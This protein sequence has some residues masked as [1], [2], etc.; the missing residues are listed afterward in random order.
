MLAPPALTVRPLP[1]A[2][3]A[4]STPRSVARVPSWV[5]STADAV[6]VVA[7]DIT[8]RKQA[9]AALL[10]DNDTW[11]ATSRFRALIEAD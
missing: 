2:S 1:N 8:E 6:L 7:M 3:C 4:G 11:R 10:K 5:A 9:E